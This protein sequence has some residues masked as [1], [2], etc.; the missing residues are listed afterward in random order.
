MEAGLNGFR[1]KRV[2]YGKFGLQII[3]E[4][5][6]YTK[7][8]KAFLLPSLKTCRQPPP[9][10]IFLLHFLLLPPPSSSSF[11]FFTAAQWR[12][13][14]RR[15]RPPHHQHHHHTFLPFSL[16]C[17]AFCFLFPFPFVGFVFFRRLLRFSGEAS[18]IPAEIA[19]YGGWR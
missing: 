11:F 5:P 1:I 14:A 12:P 15:R 13:K 9:S 10:L 3:R 16:L 18:S 7:P 19:T 2:H 17:L 6:Y 4:P 8:N